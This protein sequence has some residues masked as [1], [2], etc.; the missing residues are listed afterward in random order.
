SVCLLSSR[1]WLRLS[2]WHLGFYHL[3]THHSGRHVCPHTVDQTTTS[4]TITR[5]CQHFFLGGILHWRADRWGGGLLQL[6]AA[7][8]P[9]RGIES[10]LGP[11]RRLPRAPHKSK[12]HGSGQRMRSGRKM[13]PVIHISA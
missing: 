7:A 10:A 2:P 8:N 1:L 9:L 11:P 3:T 12:R 13:I 6:Q 5:S 4:T